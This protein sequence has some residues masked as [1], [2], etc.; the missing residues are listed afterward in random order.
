MSISAQM[1]RE[2]R[3]RTGVGMMQCKKALVECDGDLEAAARHLRTSGQA[4][5]DKKSGRIA[6]E[7]AMLL[8]QADDGSAALLLEVNSETDFVAK[9]ENF[10]KFGQACADAALASG[11]ADVEELM[12]QG[13][14]EQ[15]C[16]L[17]A[18]LGEN[19]QVRRLTRLEADGGALSCYVHNRRIGALVAHDGDA[20]LGRGLAMHVAAF[21]PVCVSDADVPAE[22]LQS[23]REVLRAQ[24][25]GSGKP[26]EIVEKMIE[27]RLRKY[28]AGITLLG[29]AYVLDADTTVGKAVSAA[30][31]SVRGFV[32]LEVGEG[33]EKRQEDFAEEVRAQTEKFSNTD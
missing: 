27:G 13:F 3:E 24:A 23:E 4:Q 10:L 28:L 12:A 21:S 33:L 7:G 29:Q 22:L 16:D 30:G 19:I 8:A 6:A 5:A 1:V 26:A 2:L 9:D 18:K 15:R 17:I 20:E 32:R 25:E 14:E 31:A 11:V